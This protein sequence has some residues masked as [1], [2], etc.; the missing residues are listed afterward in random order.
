MPLRTDD[1]DY[2]LPP[3][4][5]ARY[6]APTRG[7]SRL[8]VSPRQ[9]RPEHRRF[10]EL[11]SLVTGDELVVV[12]D[13][14]VLRARVFGRRA[15][16][17][18]KVEM[19]FVRPDG[20]DRWIAMTRANGAL[21]PGAV[22]DLPGGASAE[23]VDRRED[24]AAVVAL[25][26]IGDDVPRWLEAHGALPLPPYLNRQAEESDVDR[27]QTI[28][29]ASDGAV[30]APTAGLH[31]TEKILES[32]RDR[33]CLIER[34]TLHVGPGTFRPVTVDDPRQHALD[35]E[36][37]VIPEATA[38]ALSAGRPVL[39]VGTTVVRALEHA[40]RVGQGAVASGPGVADLLILP[41]DPLSV[42]DR[43]LTNFHLPRSS[44]LMLVCALAG[45]E[46]TLAAY[47]AAVADQYRF[48][49]YGDATLWL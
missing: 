14:R 43:L 4:L 39:A 44:L 33:G 41:G 21:R 49:S 31:F 34:V 16:S 8:L 25:D 30:A 48:Y 36:S 28:F 20:P 5:I 24:G 46:R 18:G 6:P 23:I 27:Y 45:T 38:A 10:D 3:G 17:G 1:F 35:P 47:A 12:N 13:T 26:G 29:A 32:L 37:Y 9:G 15:G 7:G 22:V 19:L 11:S 40:Y 2:D 42:V